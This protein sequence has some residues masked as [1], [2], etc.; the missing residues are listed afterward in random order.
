MKKTA[1]ILAA[2]LMLVMVFGVFA[3]CGASPES[4]ELE[5]FINTDM[6]DITANYEDVKAEISKWEDMQDNTAIAESI[7]GKV[8]PKINDSLDKLSKITLETESVKALKDK[9]EKSMTTFK[10][11]Y[12][13][14]L[15][16]CNKNDVELSTA[17]GDKLKEG[18]KQLN[19]YNTELEKL[20]DENG[21]TVEY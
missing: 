11:G 14:M 9:Y 10:A 5:K 2:V 21:M 4:E 12:E 6:K 15:D 8:L 17:A 3:G 16:A 18:T 1:K 7:S 13:M 19:E 20:A